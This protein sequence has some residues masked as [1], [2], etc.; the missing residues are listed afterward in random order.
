MDSGKFVVC[1]GYL[2]AL[3][4]VNVKEGWD[5]KKCANA[6]NSS[7]PRELDESWHRS[8]TRDQ[9]FLNLS[10]RL[11]RRIV[12]CPPYSSGASSEAPL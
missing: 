8:R 2:D 11:Y 6:V 10:G 5:R 3:D 12:S 7:T 9:K 1:G 4:V